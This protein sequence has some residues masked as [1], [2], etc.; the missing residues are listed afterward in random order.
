MD[1][2]PGPKEA[3]PLHIL[4][5]GWSVRS[6][7]IVIHSVHQDLSLL[8]AKQS[9]LPTQCKDINPSQDL[10]NCDCSKREFKSDALICSACY[11]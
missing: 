7:A 11:L 9:L 10:E 2:L 3:F 4:T 1:G 8:L 6:F 5:E